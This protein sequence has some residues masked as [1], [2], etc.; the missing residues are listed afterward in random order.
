MDQNNLVF[1]FKSHDVNNSALESIRKHIEQIANEHKGIPKSAEEWNKLLISQKEHSKELASQIDNIK[2]KLHEIQVQSNISSNETTNSLQKEINL[3]ER[4]LKLRQ[5]DYVESRQAANAIDSLMQQQHAIPAKMLP[6]ILGGGRTQSGGGTAQPSTPHLPAE[7][8]PILP[9][10]AAKHMGDFAKGGAE[11]L[12]H[13]VTGALMGTITRVIASATNPVT[14]AAAVVGAVAF[15]AKKTMDWGWEKAAPAREYVTQSQKM[16]Y[17]YRLGEDLSDYTTKNNPGAAGLYSDKELMEEM[18]PAIGGATGST[19]LEGA[20]KNKYL[21][22]LAKYTREQGM[23]FGETAQNLQIGMRGGMILPSGEGTTESLAVLTNAMTSGAKLGFDRSERVGQLQKVIQL[24]NRDLGAIYKDTGK[25][26]VAEL[27]AFE[28]AGMRGVTGDRALD[29]LANTKG[30]VSNMPIQRYASMQMMGLLPD[31]EEEA[32]KN[33]ADTHGGDMKTARETYK[34]M[35]PAQQMQLQRQTLLTS[36]ESLPAMSKLIKQFEGREGMLGMM[37]KGGELTDKEQTQ[38]TDFVMGVKQ[39]KFNKEALSAVLGEQDKMPKDH[40]AHNEKARQSE[41]AKMMEDQV[42]LRGALIALDK[43]IDMQIGKLNLEMKAL[44]AFFGNSGLTNTEQPKGQR[45]PFEE[46]TPIG[47]FF[48]RVENAAEKPFFNFLGDTA[49]GAATSVKEAAQATYP[50]EFKALSSMGKWIS[51]RWAAAQGT[52][53]EAHAANPSVPKALINAV[54]RAESEYNPKAVSSAGAQGMMQLMPATARGLNVK[55]PFD[56]EQNI[57][58]GTKHLAY[59][60][61]KYNGDM[62]KAV[63]A[64]NAGE[65]TV[66]KAIKKGKPLPQETQDYVPKVMKYYEEEKQREANS[67]IQTTLNKGMSTHGSKKDKEFADEFNTKQIKRNKVVEESKESTTNKSLDVTNKSNSVSLMSSHVSSVNM[68]TDN[69]SQSSTH[70]TSDVP[71]RDSKK[72]VI[73][74]KSIEKHLAPKQNVLEKQMSS[75]KATQDKIEKIYNKETVLKEKQI[76]K[77]QKNTVRLAEERDNTR[78]NSTGTSASGVNVNSV[79]VDV[80]GFTITQQGRDE[81]KKTFEHHLVPL[82]KSN[83]KR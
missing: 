22:Y 71:V 52:V 62:E 51:K 49:K 3:L 57:H 63:A 27:R 59:L 65:G 47:R 31:M 12:A 79:H 42:K 48:N 55:N 34:G 1:K 83:G 35:T 46:K 44:N 17:R 19:Y 76:E 64:Y 20:N 23:S 36:S 50:K 54:I 7:K 32:I 16:S 11:A 13:G 15:G 14:L 18:Y 39:G 33:L 58:G 61:E 72:E 4:R 78:S 10:Q 9:E 26:M 28:R 81:M 38:W 5:K 77:E 45:K 75:H 66:N 70:S 56:P 67:E 8:K 74:E 41:Q 21:P 60:L 68:R 30:M 40:I 6:A 69:K 24:G 82:P 29:M 2:T 25:N 43:T 73:K 80:P 37:L 53:S